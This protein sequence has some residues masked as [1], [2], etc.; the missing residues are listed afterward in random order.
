VQPLIAKP[1]KAFIDIR[2]RPSVATPPEEDRA[3]ATG[4]LYTKHFVT[5]CFRDMIADRQTHTETN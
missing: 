3:T 1:S 4:D 5:I 2:L